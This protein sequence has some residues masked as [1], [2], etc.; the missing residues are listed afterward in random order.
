MRTFS[1]I[2]GII[3][4]LVLCATGVLM[5]V[6]EPLTAM[7]P[8]V[9]PADLT[10]YTVP[11][12]TAPEVELKVAEAAAYVAGQL[13]LPEADVKTVNVPTYSASSY[14]TSNEYLFS[15]SFGADFY[16][17]I[18]NASYKIFKQLVEMS[19]ALSRT[20]G[21]VSNLHEVAKQGVQQMNNLGE[22]IE[23]LAQFSA[24]QA[25]ATA[26]MAAQQAQA[27]EAIAAVN[28]NVTALYEAENAQLA[29]M[30]NA[31]QGMSR[32]IAMIGLLIRAIGVL[33]AAI[34]LTN[35][36]KY[37]AMLSNDK[38]AQTEVQA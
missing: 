30:N 14:T 32:I 29:Q 27:T 2:L 19:T 5:T 35:L 26:D 13:Q 33:V 7:M 3:V 6:A 38:K 10:T 17:E 8:E 31:A 37:L 4:S 23:L 12:V 24:A 1:A 9:V 34:G 16:S 21:A 22:G 36:C 28:A 15:Y 25:Q 11:T 18:Y 20:S